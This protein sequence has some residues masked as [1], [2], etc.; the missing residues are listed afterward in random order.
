MAG[1][2]V[3]DAAVVRPWVHDAVAG[4]S[5]LDRDAALTLAREARA[6]PRDVCWFYLRTLRSAVRRGNLANLGDAEQP[7]ALA[8]LLEV[9]G[10]SQHVVT[11]GGRSAV[12]AV[13]L[14]IDDRSRRIT[15]VNP[16]AGQ[17]QR[18]DYMQFVDAH[19]R[20]QIDFC[21]EPTGPLPEALRA[22]DLVVDVDALLERNGR[23]GERH[24]P[25]SGPAKRG[26]RWFAFTGALV[27]LAAAV[28][29]PASLSES[30]P[31]TSGSSREA[32]RAQ[33]VTPAARPDAA[34]TQPDATSGAGAIET[35]SRRPASQKAV[36]AKPRK[37]RVRGP[38]PGAFSGTGSRD[39]GTLHVDRP[40]TLRWTAGRPFLIVSREWRFRAGPPG[41]TT[42]L[43]PGTYRRF[44][45]RSP[46]SWRLKLDPVR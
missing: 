32:V 29:L 18:D 28:M 41:G 25:E 16:L 20:A 4:P 1:P 11:L 24:V 22:P 14:A 44:A 42:L 9:A 46:A 35:A 43:T 6:L 12:S 8:N 7:A 2:A 21:S 39:L 3:P 13:A 30:L 5:V 27:G 33:P 31:G 34:T 45:V 26:V 40:T 15:V 37:A 10:T 36:Q 17:W 19:V 23:D 38:G